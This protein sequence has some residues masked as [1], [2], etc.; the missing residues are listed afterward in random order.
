MT[1]IVRAEEPYS[2]M[3]VI[4]MIFAIRT[5]PQRRRDAMM[6]S[7]QT[8][9]TLACVPIETRNCEVLASRLRDASR[10]PANIGLVSCLAAE[11]RGTRAR[12]MHASAAIP[13]IPKGSASAPSVPSQ[14]RSRAQSNFRVI[15]RMSRTK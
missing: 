12:M 11:E 5:A 9:S 1:R 8:Y 4:S 10:L 6:H 3:H 2:E 14:Q 7:W 13:A 15:D